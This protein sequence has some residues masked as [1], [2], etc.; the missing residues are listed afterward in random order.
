[1][2]KWIAW[3]DGSS[4]GNPG[5]SGYGYRIDRGKQTV[6]FGFSPLG[7]STNNA[8]EYAAVEAALLK[9]LELEEKPKKATV[10][11]QTDSELVVKQ[12]SGSYAVRAKGLK[13]YHKR[14]KI[15]VGK[16]SQVKFVHIPREKNEVA[17][18][19]ANQGSILAKRNEANHS[20]G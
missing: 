7:V 17:D 1:M 6:A 9:V 8:A 18:F 4:Y 3:T 10:L 15:A 16:F 5:P 13:P 14:L 11:V 2:A 12:L 20:N 19:L